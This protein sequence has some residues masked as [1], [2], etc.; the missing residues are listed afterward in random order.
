MLHR[1]RPSIDRAEEAT[2]AQRFQRALVIDG[3]TPAGRKMLP[4]ARDPIRFPAVR[5]NHAG[6]LVL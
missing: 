6:P 1:C 2:R 3:L 4:N 5:E